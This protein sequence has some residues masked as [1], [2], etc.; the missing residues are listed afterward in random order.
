[1]GFSA[2]SLR[3]IFNV[4]ARMYKNR[5]SELLNRP[6]HV[7]PDIACYYQNE[8]LKPTPYV[9]A[10]INITNIGIAIIVLIYTLSKR[11]C[12]FVLVITL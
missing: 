5:R 12:C 3:V 10:H 9:Y 4:R 7:G 8:Q 1:M 2:D 6:A 11:F